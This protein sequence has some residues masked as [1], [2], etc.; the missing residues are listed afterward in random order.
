MHIVPKPIKMI[1]RIKDQHAIMV[2]RFQKEDLSKKVQVPLI[3]IRL[4]KVHGRYLQLMILK[5]NVSSFLNINL[6]LNY[7]VILKDPPI[8]ILIQEVY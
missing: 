1:I 2:F 4:L 3:L 6:F 7:H 5:N 8:F